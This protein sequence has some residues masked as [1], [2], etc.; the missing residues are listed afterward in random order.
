MP[1]NTIIVWEEK[2]LQKMIQVEH[3]STSSE[4]QKK[5]T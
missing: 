4:E 1:R 2:L 3:P 5:I